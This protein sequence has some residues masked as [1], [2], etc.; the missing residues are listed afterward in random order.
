[1]TASNE[2]I[3]QKAY[4]LLRYTIPMLNK[5]PRSQRFTL[6]DRIQNS[7]TE[8]LEELIRAYYSPAARKKELLQQVNIRLEILRHHFRL[9][10]DLGLYS[11]LKYKEFAERLD[12][13]G[14]MTGGWL[15]SLK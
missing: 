7:L 14:R 9:C 11:S 12:E 8:L 2:T 13:I 3:V 6:A 15:K 1:M 4:D 10:Y 5:F